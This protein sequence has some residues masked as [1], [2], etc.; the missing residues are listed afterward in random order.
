MPTSADLAAKCL[1]ALSTPKK[2]RVKVV[3]DALSS[4]MLADPQFVSPLVQALSDKSAVFADTLA[5]EILPHIGSS[6][7]DPLLVGFD[8][9][10]EP[11]RYRHLRVIRQLAPD[12]AKNYARLSAR[13]KHLNL[14]LE[15][16]EILSGSEADSSLLME[17][18]GSR[19]IERSAAAYRAL[20]GIPNATV[21]EFL[22]ESLVQ[23][24]G[25]P[26]FSI[27][28][29]PNPSLSR[30][31]SDI[32]SKQLKSLEAGEIP[33]EPDARHLISLIASAAGQ[34]YE[35]FDEIFVRCIEIAAKIKGTIEPYA[36][37]AL[38]FAEATFEAV[39]T[40][41]APMSQ[42]LLVEQR[43]R[44]GAQYQFFA[45]CAAAHLDDVPL[46]ETFAS[47]LADQNS[48]GRC[49]GWQCTCRMR[50]WPCSIVSAL[51]Y[52]RDDERGLKPRG[53]PLPQQATLID[54]IR[55]EPRWHDALDQLEPAKLTEA[56]QA[57]GHQ[58]PTRPES[59]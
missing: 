24:I 1:A 3:R 57:G 2:G 55:D 23:G 58:P 14:S 47:S 52:V 37:F 39:A 36:T 43:E 32:L 35:P 17:L 50:P 46:F 38:D 6:L 15:C 29:R 31:I 48:R 56:E 7:V 9:L 20:S 51:E 16:I 5:D 8:E 28:Y 41:P 13:T 40:N 22:R 45:L 25:F 34:D 33:S 53:H 21:H 18:A 42:R 11:V 54:K 49:R 44:F 19:A 4:G 10:P 30:T 27:A 26:Q 12:D 59:T